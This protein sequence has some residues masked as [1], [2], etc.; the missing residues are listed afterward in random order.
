MAAGGLAP[1]LILAPTLPSA[2][3]HRDNTRPAADEPA[4]LLQSPLHSYLWQS[5]HDR[6]TY[7]D[8]PPHP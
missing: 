2:G 4:G 8:R 7:T 1:A 3:T 5:R 6:R